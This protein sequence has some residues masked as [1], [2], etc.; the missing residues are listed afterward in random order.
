[1]KIL[2]LPLALSLMLM[3]SA[4]ANAATPS[5][6]IGDTVIKMPLAED[7]S[8]DD[9]ITSMK[10]RANNLNFKL[11]AY[12]PL[13]KELQSMGV[14][15]KR[16]EIF[17]FCDARIAKAM[18]DFNPDFSAYLPCRITLLEGPDGQATLITMN[19]GM[20][21]ESANLPPELLKQAIHVRDTIQSIMQAGADGDL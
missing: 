2:K 20:F 7:V 9:A 10:L 16:I 8:I 4:F 11:V 1:M 12:L 14:K 18:I 21:I 5:L 15:S 17:Q 3:L 6:N 13:Y 19:L